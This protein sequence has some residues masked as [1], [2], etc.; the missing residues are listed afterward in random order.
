M[1]TK[2]FWYIRRAVTFVAVAFLAFVLGSF[3]TTLKLPPGPQIEG[4]M[5]AAKAVRKEYLAY[6]GVRPV[7]HLAPLRFDRSGFAGD[8]ERAMPGVTLLVSIFDE[9]FTARLYGR[10]GALIHEWPIDFFEID[11]GGDYRFH[12]LI[13]GVALMENGDL[14]AN[15]DG[16][17]IYRFSRCGD[18]VWKNAHKSHHALDIDDAGRIWTP[19]YGV[20]YQPSSLQPV[21]HQ[22]DRI[23]VFDAKTGAVLKEYDLAAILAETDLQGL[24]LANKE[25]ARDLLHLNDVEVLRA[26]M[27]AAFPLFEAGDILLSPRRLNQL[28]VLDGKT[29]KLKWWHIGPI[30]S[31]HDPDFQPDGTITVFDNRPG[32][33]P[34]KSN[35]GIGRLGGSR[36]LKIDPVT[37]AHEVM[38]ASEGDFRLY[39]AYRGKH[40]VLENGNVLIAETDA[41]RALEVTPE[42][43]IVWEYINTFDDETVAWMMDAMRYPPEFAKAFEAP[44]PS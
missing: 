39:S 15:M 38:V 44:C 22:V 2:L 42:G 4:A 1:S 32:G 31:A 18:L 16:R 33:V 29:Q 28:W 19:T 14:L 5:T 12:T 11:G 17:G 6:L 3:L 10:N 21:S 25:I 30:H 40:Q 43:D 34:N 23:G 36:V 7:E 37:R 35:G 8:P 20:P 26:D 13:H 27:A 41:G 9:R 24:V